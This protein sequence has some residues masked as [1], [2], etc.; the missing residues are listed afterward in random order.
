MPDAVAVPSDPF[1]QE[2]I[3]SR[4]ESQ[5]NRRIRVGVVRTAFGVFDWTQ[6]VSVGLFSLTLYP[7]RLAVQG[8]VSRTIGLGI[9]ATVLARMIRRTLRPASGS[10]LT[11]APSVTARMSHAATSVA[12]AFTVIA[13]CRFLSEVASPAPAPLLAWA[14]VSSAVAAFIQLAAKPE[15][16][17]AVVGERDAASKL[18]CRFKELDKR[19]RV[20]VAAVID[21][22]CREEM[23]RLDRLIAASSHCTVV[24]AAGSGRELHEALCNRLADT[25]ARVMLAFS[26]EAFP[27]SP[28]AAAG[29]RSASALPLMELLPSPISGWNRTVKRSFDV[30]VITL[31]MPFLAVFMLAIALAIR[32]DSPG[33]VLFRQW[34][35]GQ[36][37]RPVL[38]YKFRTMHIKLGDTTGA[39]RTLARDPRVTRVGRVLRRLSIDELPQV[40][41]VLRGEMSLVG[42]R[43]HPIHMKVENTYYHRAFQSYR[44]RHRMLPGITGWAQINGSRGEV[45]TFE[46]AKRRVDLDLWYI[47]NWSLTLDLWI[48]LRTAFGGFATLKAD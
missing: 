9:V 8:G 24:I 41:N 45:D 32:L 40:L 27:A 30:A 38:I 35:F 6:I 16:W 46:K 39:A 25:A 31:V 18:A 28:F 33:A 10:L 20:Q 7:E 36:S 2:L 23:D 17:I 14:V 21:S 42:P 3:E 47:A 13:A 43:P 44:V 11:G 12:M 34:R 26:D 37:S 19:D 15:A 29:V 5:R 22:N 4:A 48:I 1:L